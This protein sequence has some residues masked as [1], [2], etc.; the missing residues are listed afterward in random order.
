MLNILTR[1]ELFTP[2]LI[3]PCVGLCG[4]LYLN[5]PASGTS[6]LAG[7]KKQELQFYCSTLSITEPVVVPDILCFPW[8]E[9]G[10]L[11]YM[12][13]HIYLRRYL[14]YIFV[15]LLYSFDVLCVKDAVAV[16]T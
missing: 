14:S 4:V 1:H 16:L 11:V 15:L 5:T 9:D 7:Q 12:Y 2:H 10:E 8:M 6:V 3:S 13:I